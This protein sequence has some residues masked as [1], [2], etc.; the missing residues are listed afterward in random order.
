MSTSTITTSLT[1]AEFIQTSIKRNLV[2]KSTKNV[3]TIKAIINSFK[4]KYI[5]RVYL[6]SIH[7][8]YYMRRL[9]IYNEN[10]LKNTLSKFYF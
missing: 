6:N 4:N 5:K 7:I 1:D 2:V 10:K 9:K 3:S 8:V